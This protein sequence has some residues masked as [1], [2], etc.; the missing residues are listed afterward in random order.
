[1]EIITGRNALTFKRDDIILIW[2]VS[3]GTLFGTCLEKCI[4]W[5]NA[6]KRQFQNGRWKR[7]IACGY[8]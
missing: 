7:K 4:F 6:K 1:M 8:T 3:K 2:Q 5:Q